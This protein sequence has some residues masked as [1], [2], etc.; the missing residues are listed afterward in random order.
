M[1][2]TPRAGV[3]RLHAGR[4]SLVKR[5]RRRVVRHGQRD[6]VDHGQHI[7]AVGVEG[8]LTA[9]SDRWADSRQQPPLMYS[10]R[11]VRLGTWK[12]LTLAYNERIAAK[13]S[14]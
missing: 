11:A 6:V 10:T 8:E 2:R 9:V 13:P 4:T 12:C 7:V 1:Q 3:P 14:S 5:S